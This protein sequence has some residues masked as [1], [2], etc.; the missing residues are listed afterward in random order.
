VVKV[1]AIPISAAHTIVYLPVSQDFTT[2]WGS[3][4]VYVV[5]VCEAAPDMHL[6][7]VGGDAVGIIPH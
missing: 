4:N 5:S 1:E 7:F 3:G 2:P 6:V